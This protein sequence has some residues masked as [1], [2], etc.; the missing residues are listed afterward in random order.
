MEENK[1]EINNERKNVEPDNLEDIKEDT[2]EENEINIEEF[3]KGE[4]ELTE[5]LYKKEPV[6]V[7]VVAIDKDS[8]YVDIGEKKDGVISVKDFDGFKLPNIGS[9][10]IAVLEKR[11]TE[12]QP[13]ILSYRKAKEA[14]TLKWLE[15]A[16]A[17][18][19]RIRGRILQQV[20]GGYIVSINGVN[21]FMPL[22]LSELRG[23]SRHYLPVN[24]KVKFYLIDFN[25]QNKKIIVSRRAVME[26]DEKI[27]REKVISQ[28]KEGEYTRVVVS[29]ITDNGIFVRY[30]GIEGFVKLE[31]VDWK[32]PKEMLSHFSRGQRIKVK[33]LSVDREKQRINFGIK[34]T[35]PNPQ[36]VLRRRF[37]IRTI[38]K[39]K[40]VE[41]GENYSRV[42]IV[43][44]VYGMIS[45][46]EYSYDGPPSKDSV[47]DAAVIGI[48]PQTYELNLS[49][50]KYE[51]I[52]NRKRIEQYSKQTPK[53]T[54]G[55]L[56][57]D[58]EK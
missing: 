55:Q 58:S 6:Y 4:E 43:D 17:Q 19:E 51:Q 31:D 49:I 14:V 37:P 57:K 16:Y 10:I 32:N 1:Q 12:E 20:K 48:N 27:R 22:S 50:K 46:E 56:L 24:A 38:V 47:V 30:Q 41:V 44:D 3:L 28:T 5:K 54:L 40:V 29:K 25:P 13:A 45:E 36:D 52:E 53:I 26:E 7:K 33:I 42:H 21:A 9:K 39:G 23:T 18:R 35:R 8:V 34:Q 11:S 15:K 2:L